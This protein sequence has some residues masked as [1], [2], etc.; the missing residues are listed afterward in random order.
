MK[1]NDIHD[2]DKIWDFDNPY[3]GIEDEEFDEDYDEEVDDAL[4]TYALEEWIIKFIKLIDKN[5][6]K[7]PDDMEAM[8][9]GMVE[10]IKARRKNKS[11]H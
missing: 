11:S 2:L 3:D 1:I 9:E 5:K 6:I 7:L 8:R 4:Y 10:D